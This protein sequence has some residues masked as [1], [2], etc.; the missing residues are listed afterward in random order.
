MGRS[1][2]TLTMYHDIRNINWLPIYQLQ[3]VDHLADYLNKV[4]LSVFDVHAPVKIIECKSNQ[5]KWITAGFLSCIDT[6]EHLFH[7]Y[8]NHPTPH[9]EACKHESIHLIKRMKNQM[10]CNY[11]AEALSECKGDTKKTW[12]V[13]KALWPT[14][15]KEM[16]INKIGDNTN[17]TDIAN[18][19][20][21]HFCKLF[22]LVKVEN[23]AE[24]FS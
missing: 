20:N 2:C 11:I 24:S 3:D 1:S 9:N 14:K 19:L 23:L 10:K 6:R 22:D 5:L 15:Q 13:I 12:R 4:F 16:V 21:S 17:P 18:K 7:F 8:N